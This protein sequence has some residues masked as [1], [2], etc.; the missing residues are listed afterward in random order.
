[1]DKI[2]R[3]ISVRQF[4]IMYIIGTC[5]SII[6]VLPIYGSFFAKEATWVSTIVVLIPFFA[7]IYM[8]YRIT[9]NRERQR[10]SSKL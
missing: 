4:I 5:T 8:L 10:F 1:M 3:K 2:E 6:R 9:R 7:V